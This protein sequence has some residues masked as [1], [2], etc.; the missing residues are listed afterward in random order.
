MEGRAEMCQETWS[1]VGSLA[2]MQRLGF[3]HALH[4]FVAMCQDNAFN[5]AMPQCPHM[6]PPRV[7]MT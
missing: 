4:H 6:P 1:L 7:V 5:A 2:L 3:E